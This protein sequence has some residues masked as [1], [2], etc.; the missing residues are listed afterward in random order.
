MQENLDEDL[1]SVFLIDSTLR[2]GRQCA[3]VSLSTRD[4]EEILEGL[5]AIAVDMVE[6]G[7]PSS[8]DD[9]AKMLR[10]LCSKKKRPPLMGHARCRS[11]DIQSVAA[12]GAEWVGLFLA[13][14]DLARKS[15][16]RNRDPEDLLSLIASSVRYARNEGLQVRYT[17][18]D[19]SRTEADVRSRAFR[20]ACDAGADRICIADTV[21]L[22][23]PSEVDSIVRSVR[24]EFAGVPLEVHFHDDRGLAMANALSAVM[25]GASWV[26][27]SINGLGERCGIT[28]IA[29]LA[30]NLEMLGLRPMCNPSAL[31]QLS[32]L[33]AALSRSPVDHRRPVVG[34]NAFT[35]MA[36]LHKKAVEIDPMTYSGIPP[37]RVGRRMS[38]GAPQVPHSVKELSIVPEA[39]SATE[40]RFHRHGPGVRY[41][42]LDESLIED[43][44]NYV[45]IR[46]IP[47]ETEIGAPHVDE[48]RHNVD[49]TFLFFGSGDALTGL[50]VE[51]TLENETLI[52]SSPVAVFI[53]SGVRHAY[54]ILEGAGFF[55]NQVAAGNYNSSLLSE[56]F[57]GER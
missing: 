45:I 8:S 46:H 52:V 34:R 37:D 33:T 2:E 14:N 5:T 26:S 9:D 20:A 41:L 4:S 27:C 39:R 47:E 38:L 29:T 50:T 11:E 51:V 3:G 44:R 23:I 19:A 36:A 56:G 13:C 24:S 40:L 28:D 18:E 35:H 55:I 42:L 1:M 10:T 57:D 22:L 54:R 48:H 25:A 31:Q 49:S 6:C 43:C 32:T 17:L 53:P 16:L 30:L 12:C 7:H 15:R 21:G